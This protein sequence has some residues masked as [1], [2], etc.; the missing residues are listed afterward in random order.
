MCPGEYFGGA[1]ADSL[2]YCKN[3]NKMIVFAVLMDDSGLTFQGQGGHHTEVFVF[4]IRILVTFGLFNLQLQVVLMIAI[5]KAATNTHTHTT[6]TH[7][8]TPQTHT[9]T[10]ARAQLACA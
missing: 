9:H 10:H 5:N 1:P 8:H 7:S 6:Q 3:G 4:G 2:G